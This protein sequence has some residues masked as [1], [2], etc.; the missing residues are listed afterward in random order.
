MLAASFSTKS[1]VNHRKLIS[2]VKVIVVVIETK[3]LWF[4][5]SHHV[6]IQTQCLVHIMVIYCVG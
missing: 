5:I 2:I 1:T 6:Y 4:Q 3:C